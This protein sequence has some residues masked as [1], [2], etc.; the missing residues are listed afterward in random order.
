MIFNHMILLMQAEVERFHAGTLLLHDYYQTKVQDATH[1]NSVV[2]VS[3]IIFLSPIF[4]A[5]PLM[6]LKFS[7]TRM[8]QM[9]HRH[10]DIRVERVV[11]ASSAHI[12]D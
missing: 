9:A 4:S 12:I 8:A 7:P 2:L 10:T 11:F 5:L 6:F 1:D 3:C